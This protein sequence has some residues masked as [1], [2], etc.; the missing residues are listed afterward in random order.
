M[1]FKLE[2]CCFNLGSALIAQEAGAHRIEL[3]ADPGDGGTTPSQGVIREA[4]Q[5]LHIELYPIIRPRGGDFLFS[6]EEF[7]VMERDVVNC[8]QTGCDGVVIGLL[9]ADGT[10]DKERSVRLVELAYPLGV[11]FHRAF[12]RTIDP[13]QALEDIIGIG[14][15]RILSS[16]LRPTAVEGSDLLRELVRLA[17]ERIIIMPGSGIRASN[18]ATLAQDIGAGEWHSSARVKIASSMKYSNAAMGEDQP[19]VMADAVEIRG[20]L[21]SLAAIGT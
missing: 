17:D 16:G 2:I 14:C 9:K 3:C 15:E 13:V 6:A 21:G 5:R 19:V 7:A 11:T 1:A 12:D 8:K 20:M 10:V 18:I 4:R